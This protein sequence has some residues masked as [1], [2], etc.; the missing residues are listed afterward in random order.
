[1]RARLRDTVVA[2]SAVVAVSGL[3]SLPLL[4]RFHGLD[5]DLLHWLRAHIAAPDR[6]PVDSP[7][8]VIAIDE[9]THA[10]A[11]FEGIPKVMWTPQIAAVQ[12]AVLEAGAKV[13]GWDVILPTSAS[14]YLK[15]RRFDQAL[16]KS[17]RAERRSGRIVLGRAQLSELAILPHRAFAMMAGGAANIRNLDISLDDDGISRS[18]PLFQKMKAKSG[19][20]EEVTGMAMELAARAM[21]QRPDLSPDG[22]A[23]L[24]SALPGG[25]ERELTLNFDARAGAIPT[26][27]L[28]DLYHCA[29]AGNA[30]YFKQAFAGKVV[31]FGLVLDIE[32]RKLSS[33]R[34]INRPD[35]EGAPRPCRNPQAEP[36]KFAA[37]STVPG[38]YLHATAVNNLIN[39]DA[40]ELPGRLARNALTIPLAVLG[41]LLTLLLTPLRASLGLGVAAG[42]WSLATIWLFRDAVVLPLIAPLAVMAL[43][44]VATLGYRFI[45]IDKDKR[46]LRDAFS[47]YVSPNLVEVIVN[48]P[49]GSA[50]A[51]RRQECSFIFTDLAGFTSLVEGTD[52]KLLHP[53]LN[54]Y[55][56]GMVAIAFKHSGTL[57][58]VV[59]DALTIIF[60]APIEQPNHAQRAVDCALELDAWARAYAI[61]LNEKGIA[62]G[63]TRVG[64]NTGPVVVGN[65]GG[66]NLFD[67]TAHG[68]A[69]N[70]A[71]RL[72]SVNKHLG[73]NVCISGATA[74]KCQN[75]VG[76]PMGKLVLKGK[77]EGTEA[78]EPLTETEM[79][80]PRVQAYLA[81]YHL[82][83]ANDP[84]AAEAFASAA[85]NFPG[86]PLVAFHH[87]WLKKGENGD[88]VVMAEK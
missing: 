46:F 48:D 57:D 77:S 17:F 55:I 27:S 61:G 51:A 36:A 19:K 54:D 39:G 42:L 6:G 84:R 68:D 12:E 43:S 66:S 9:K 28:A 56:D 69:I 52:P 7:A 58:K 76:R 63:K 32:D 20:V 60:S 41:A 81:A 14:T 87:E 18:V 49:E 64:V 50:V 3:A 67:Y 78:F 2:L 75:F 40:L 59:G 44:S 25:K 71:A 86:D 34:L 30:G 85:A 65:F 82:M 5:I 72:E 62:L 37:R 22:V 1:M 33:N 31:L 88:T 53:I 79:D 38:V 13:F 83:A 70:T 16:L 4:E 74:E 15:N 10:T 35:L 11:P 47:S 29:K 23:F 21:G 80:S 45:V 24:G 8:V 73:T 26:Y